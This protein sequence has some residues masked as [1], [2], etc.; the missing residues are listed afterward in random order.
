MV[1]I[2]RALRFDGGL[3]RREPEAKPP[4]KKHGKRK[5]H[6]DVS[7]V[8]AEFVG[9]LLRGRFALLG[10]LD[11]RD[12]FLQRAFGGGPR[13]DDFDRAPKIDGAGERGV[14]D[15]LLDGRGFAGE[16][17][18][19][20]GGAAFG[21]FGVHGKLRAGLDEQAHSALELL[22]FD[23]AL[24]APG[25]QRGGDFRRVAEERADFLLRPA[26]R[27]MFERAG[28]R[29][30]KQQRGAFAPRADAGRA[31]GD[32]D[33]E[34]MH[35]NRAFLETFPNVFRRIK[36]AREIG[37]NVSRHRPITG[38]QKMP[39][40]PKTPQRIAAASCGFH[41]L[42]CSSMCSALSRNSTSRGTTLGNGMSRQRQ[43]FGAVGQVMRAMVVVWPSFWM[44]IFFRSASDSGVSQLQAIVL[45]GKQ[46]A[47]AFG[48]GGLRGLKFARDAF[49]ELADIGPA[50]RGDGNFLVRAVNRHRLERRFL[51]QR[52]HDRAR[53]AMPVFVAGLGMLFGR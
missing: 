19:V 13:N 52:V 8:S 49:G 39:A 29:K 43:N 10:F 25:I 27:V 51:G 33:H 37:Q 12:D 40:S 18:F 6:G 50:Q 30:Q 21:D 9:E 15:V 47:M 46:G 32:E 5:S 31:G 41:S 44:V 2:K 1:A 7:V 28:K 38:Q 36:T 20:R 42:I 34:K 24:A 48:G 11:E 14:A 3:K 23:F 35:V 26:Q 22:D 17:R 45:A 16:I 53:E 4:D